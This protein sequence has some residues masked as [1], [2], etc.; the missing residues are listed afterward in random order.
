MNSSNGPFQIVIFWVFRALKIPSSLDLSSATRSQQNKGYLHVK[1]NGEK[2]ETS[3]TKC[4]EIE[5]I[6]KLEQL[7]LYKLLLKIVWE[8][9]QSLE[10]SWSFT[11]LEDSSLFLKLWG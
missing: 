8:L 7:G 11:L 9:D 1:K 4:T 3:G 5:K 10:N 6:N 2:I